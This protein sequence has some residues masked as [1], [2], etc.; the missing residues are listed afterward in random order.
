MITIKSSNP[1]YTEEQEHHYVCNYISLYYPDVIYFT[2][3]SGLKLTRNLA[4]RFSKLKSSRGIPDIII[5]EPKGKYHGLFIELK[6]TGSIAYKKD[7]SIKQDVH[8]EEQNEVL[9]KL[10]KKG[11]FACFCMGRQ[12]SIDIINWYMGLD[13]DAKQV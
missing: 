2:D 4:I 11:Y 5:P 1:K 7:G 6:R 3:G 10:K 12:E 13:K 8:L 9:E